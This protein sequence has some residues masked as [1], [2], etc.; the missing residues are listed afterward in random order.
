MD[1]FQGLEDVLAHAL[2]TPVF[3]YGEPTL[4][5]EFPQFLEMCG[6]YETM[7]SF[8]TNGMRLTPEMCECIVENRVYEVAIS[9]SGAS[10]E[11]YEAVYVGGVWETVLEGIREL[12]RQK[13]SRGSR[14]PKI[15]VNSIGFQH[16]VDH[17]EEFVE[18]MADAGANRV[19]LIPLGANLPQL[20]HHACI[21][22]SWVEGEIIERAKS[23]ARSRDM[24]A[25]FDLFDAN[26]VFSEAEY[27]AAREAMLADLPGMTEEAPVAIEDLVNLSVES[28]PRP[29]DW[30][31]AEC[32]AEGDRPFEGYIPAS[33]LGAEGVYC[34]EPF[35]TL[36]VSRNGELKPCCNASF[37]T[38]SGNL[39]QDG[40]LEV[41]RG[42]SF[43]RV[44]RTIV[45]GGYPRMCRW[46]VTHEPHPNHT[47]CN[48]AR[49]YAEWYEDAFSVEMPA[50]WAETISAIDKA[51]SSCDIADRQFAVLLE[52]NGYVPE[53]DPRVTGLIAR[54]AGLDV[55]RS[56]A[57][58]KMASEY[59]GSTSWRST[60]PLRSVRRLGGSLRKVVRRIRRGADAG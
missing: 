16:H 18:V 40:A 5:P 45:E 55:A 3:G 41:W 1:V 53:Q 11:A 8:F 17:L 7:A 25:A 33:E 12:D 54:A 21:P 2:H 36:Y 51:G 29:S 6:H 34:F 23:L 10:K 35:N 32:P 4:N 52:G 42:D 9:M 50:A 39:L 14:F 37:P 24:V 47:F 43:S 13:K 49:A 31:A 27:Q 26:M 38:F 20:V 30:V 48:T 56:K 60:G 15:S 28:H 59:E 58:E 19:L 57:L 44:R 22:R 46:C